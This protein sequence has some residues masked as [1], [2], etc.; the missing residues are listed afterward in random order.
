[1]AGHLGSLDEQDV[2]PDRGPG[3]AHRRTGLQLALHDLVVQVTRRAQGALD[4][5]RIDHDP[6]RV[7]FRHHARPFSD[8]TADLALQV[9][10]AS[11]TGVVTNQQL[12]GWASEA[13][14]VP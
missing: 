6:L 8:H 7:T 3:Q 14:H 5:L 11:L 2:A 4:E 1:M 12:Y 10:H 9:A 13:D